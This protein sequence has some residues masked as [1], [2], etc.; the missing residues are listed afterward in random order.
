MIFTAS[1]QYFIILDY[2]SQL[3]VHSLSHSAAALDVPGPP[4]TIGKEMLRLQVLRTGDMA[5]FA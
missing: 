3:S 2:I 1:Q 4:S 5:V